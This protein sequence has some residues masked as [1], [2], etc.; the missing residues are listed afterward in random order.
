MQEMRPLKKKVSITLDWDLLELLK[1]RAEDCDRS[2]SQYIN[3]ALKEHIA[4]EKKDD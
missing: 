2:L 3:L 4:R 1:E